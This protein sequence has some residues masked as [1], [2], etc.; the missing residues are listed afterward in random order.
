MKT[1]T[2][3]IFFFLASIAYSQH[4]IFPKSGLAIQCEI[5]KVTEDSI[6]FVADYGNNTLS[7]LPLKSIIHYSYNIVENDS[8]DITS[9]SAVFD[10]SYFEDLSIGK[11]DLINSSGSKIKKSIVYNLNATLIIVGTA[12]YSYFSPAPSA[13]VLILLGAT[14]LGFN[15]ASRVVLYQAGAYLEKASDKR[16][17]DFTK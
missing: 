17:K 8:L 15:I 4:T 5:R 3:L 13:P 16:R 10:S 2:T 7:K 14:A 6:F 11:W 12:A 1:I 9:Q